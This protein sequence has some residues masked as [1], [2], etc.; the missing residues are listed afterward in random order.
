MYTLRS[1]SAAAATALY[2]VLVIEDTLV[3]EVCVFGLTFEDFD[4]LLVVFDYVMSW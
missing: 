1:I 4:I 3:R 2:P